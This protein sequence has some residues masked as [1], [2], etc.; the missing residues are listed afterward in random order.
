M[1]LSAGT[2]LQITFTQTYFVSKTFPRAIHLRIVLI[3]PNYVLL[4]FEI[5]AGIIH[6]LIS[7]KPKSTDIVYATF[8]SYLRFLERR[9]WFMIFAYLQLFA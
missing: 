6:F 5:I 9:H 8:Q 3:K 4:Q 1:K 7:H 2:Q